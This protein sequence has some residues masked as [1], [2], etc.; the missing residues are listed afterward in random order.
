ML[1][2]DTQDE[3]DSDYKSSWALGAG[4]ARRG[5]RTRLYASAEWY[6]PVGRFDVIQLPEG[7]P[8][9]SGLTQ[10]LTGVLNAGVGFEHVLTDDVSVYGA[11]HTDFSASEGSARQNVAISDWDLYHF[12]GGL[13]F[14][15][16]DNRFTLGA[17]WARG[18]TDAP[19]RLAG[20]S[21]TA[22]PGAPGPGRHDPLLENHVPARV[23]VRELTWRRGAARAARWM[24]AAALLCA[25]PGAAASAAPKVDVVV[26]RNGSRV[27]GE[28]RSMTKSRLELKTDDMGTLQIEWDNVAQVTAPEFFEVEHMNG[29]LSLGALRPGKGEGTLEVVADWGTDELP[30][31]QVARI[32]LV[33]GGFWDKFRGSFDVGAGYT[34]ATELLQLDFDAELRYTRPRFEAFAQADA[35]VTQQPEADDTRRSSLTLGYTRIFPNRHRIFTQ[36]ALEQ[37][38]ELGFDLRSSVLGGWAYALAR[39]RKNQLVGGAG[40]AVNREKPIEGE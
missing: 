3:L 20:A 37:N 23:R 14:R 35:V 10:Q 5:A 1:V 27:I 38:R 9:A 4:I 21:R 19:A 34:S 16:R 40:L 11:F 29:G 17:S 30:L 6:A 36:A 28:I 39:D 22:A 8:G 12:S 33:K 26:L 2:T 24:R 15:F 31:W 13:S 25:L 7:T 32:Q 18:N